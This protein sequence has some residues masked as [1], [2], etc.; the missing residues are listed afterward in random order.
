MAS[1][2][3]VLIVDDHE[4]VRT[5]IVSFMSGSSGLLVVGETGSVQD[6]IESVGRDRPDVVVMD[7]QLADGSGI[8]ACRT[9][10]E[11]HP[12]TRVVMFTAFADTT[13]L[14]GALDAGAS[15]YV[16][17]RMDLGVLRDAVRTAAAGGVVLDPKA[18]AALEA[19]RATSTDLSRLDRLSPQERRVLALIAEGL[20]NRQIARQL[21]LAEKTVKNY[22]STVLRKLEMTRRSE[23]AAFRAT[24]DAE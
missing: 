7:V 18:E 10:R 20:T 1:P 16:L 12:E 6:A 11:Q 8:D 9:I 13:L 22:V 21:A 24:I 17:K 2:I 3:R 15:G 4:V 14:E 23:A 5:G 19:G